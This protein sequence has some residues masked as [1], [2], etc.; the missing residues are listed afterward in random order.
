MKHLLLLMLLCTSLSSYAQTN[1]DH[2]K[3]GKFE[4][5]APEMK[6]FTIIRTATTQTEIDNNT[7]AEVSGP[8]E[9]ISDCEYVMTCKKIT[10]KDMQHLINKKI[11]TKITKSEGEKYTC[12]ATFEGMEFNMEIIKVTDQ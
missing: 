12:T 9:W 2:F 4:Y 5:T 3:V 10:M 6:G 1:C 7:G 11:T 8:I